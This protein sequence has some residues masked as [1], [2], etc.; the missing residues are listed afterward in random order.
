MRRFY[1]AKPPP[2]AVAGTSPKYD[3]GILYANNNFI[4]VFGG[5]REGAQCIIAQF[6]QGDS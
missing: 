3:I 4:V 1:R 6:A 5:G 2:P